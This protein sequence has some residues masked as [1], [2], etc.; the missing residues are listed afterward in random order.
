MTSREGCHLSSGCR[1]LSEIVFK[2]R[3]YWP[4][5]PPLV[6]VP[7]PPVPVPVDVPVP[8]PML[9]SEL[10]CIDVS[11]PMEVSILI[12]EDP[13]LSVADPWF[14]V[15]E[16]LPVSLSVAVLLHAPSANAMKAR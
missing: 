11:A 4:R 1:P 3:N 6:P 10:V 13:V 7:D 12:P 9:V 15:V 14:N 5:V 2:D 16:S 8:D